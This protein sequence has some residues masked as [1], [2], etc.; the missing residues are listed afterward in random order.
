MM[1]RANNQV[2][3]NFRVWHYESTDDDF[4]ELS[5]FE[6]KNLSSYPNYTCY[7]RYINLHNDPRFPIDYTDPPAPKDSETEQQKIYREEY[8]YYNRRKDQ[9]RPMWRFHKSTLELI[10]NICRQIDC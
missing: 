9:E 3:N 2:I 4:V 6:N 5:V 7:D 1:K 8:E 10:I